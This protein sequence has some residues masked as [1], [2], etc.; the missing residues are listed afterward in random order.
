MCLCNS[1]DT[2]QDNDGN[3]IV[4]CV[5]K[6]IR[7]GI[8]IMKSIIRDKDRGVKYDI[9]CNQENQ[10]IEPN[11]SKLTSYIGFLV[12]R[13]VPITFDHWNKKELKPAKDKIWSEIKVP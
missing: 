4:R 3:E 11:G 13:E 10:L 5:E 2:V 9:H 7:R 1:F 8:T 6:D 12:R